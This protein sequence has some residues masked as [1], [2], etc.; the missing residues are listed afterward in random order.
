[1]IK[2][3]P[4]KFKILVAMAQKGFNQKSL[5]D[6]A[7]VNPATLSRFLNGKLSISP[8]SA[9]KISDALDSELEEIFEIE[10]KESEVESQCH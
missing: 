2:Y 10:I 9:R 5:S 3:H 8:N 4:R 1:M 7:D 6:A